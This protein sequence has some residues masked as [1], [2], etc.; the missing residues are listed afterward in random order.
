MCCAYGGVLESRSLIVHHI[1]GSYGY[2]HLSS[3][4]VGRWLL[5]QWVEGWWLLDQWD[6]DRWVLMDIRMTCQQ[7]VGLG[8]TNE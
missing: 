3:Q 4:I 2:S 8:M 1:H 6:E 5:D 7:L